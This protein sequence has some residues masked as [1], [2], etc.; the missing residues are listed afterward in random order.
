MSK[1]TSK[2]IL[3]VVIVSI[4]IG[5]G[6]YFLK[7]QNKISSNL[8]PTTLNNS[9][10]S[11][12]EK[13]VSDKPT[14]TSPSNGDVIANTTIT[15]KGKTK[16]NFLVWA[17]I[18]TPASEQLGINSYANGGAGKADLNGNFAFDL[19]EPCSHNLTVVLAAV[20]EVNSNK[21]YWSKSDLS[22]PVSFTT[23][24]ALPFKCSQ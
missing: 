19:A 11:L 7:N 6:I 14:I 1:Q 16:P 9:Q 4:I 5:G 24:G 23:T 15:I 3:V 17:Y 2:I 8:T 22:E 12:E 10:P 13:I 21:E 20:D 18:N